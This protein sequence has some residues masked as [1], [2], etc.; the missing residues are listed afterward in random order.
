M[1]AGGLPPISSADVDAFMRDVKLLVERLGGV[2]KAREDARPVSGERHAIADSEPAMSPRTALSALRSFKNDLDTLPTRDDLVSMLAAVKAALGRECEA[3]REDVTEWALAHDA[4]DLPEFDKIWDSLVEVSVTPLKLIAFAKRHGWRGLAKDEFTP[5]DDATD[6]VIREADALSE[7]ARTRGEERDAEVEAVSEQ[8]VY[9]SAAKKW[10]ELGTGIEHD[11][12]GLS[13]STLGLRIAPAGTVGQKSAGAILRNKGLVREVVGKTYAPGLP[14]LFTGEVGSDVGLWFNTATPFPPV[15]EATEDDVKP[16]LDHV[17]WLFPDDYKSVL[18]W[19]AYTIHRPAAKIR[20]GLCVI[21]PQGVGKDLM[22]KPIQ[23]YLGGKHYTNV[24][25]HEMESDFN[26]WIE[27]KL[28]IGQELRSD[29]RTDLYQKL[30][31]WI[32]GTGDDTIMVNVKMKTPY[33][34][35]NLASWFFMSNHDN[36]FRIEADERRLHVIR[37]APTEAR[38]AA[39]YDAY[40]RWIEEPGSAQKVAGYLKTV[41]LAEFSADRCPA[42]TNAKQEMAESSM[43]IAGEWLLAQFREEG[44]MFYGRT[45]VAGKEL[46]KLTLDLS[47]PQEVRRGIH[48]RAIG[49][50][51]KTLGWKKRLTKDD[52][53][54]LTLYCKTRELAETEARFAKHRWAKEVGDT[55]LD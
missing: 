4:C 28:L 51:L 32:S 47:I 48:T 11:N 24:K 14:R 30:K 13:Y 33:P 9:W 44:G 41:D 7:V 53:T 42:W 20:W 8:L 31:E 5:Q 29:G 40:M 43:G 2:E 39:Y 18:W 52:G 34:V 3:H 55:S 22:L 46:S 6:H 37:T 23:M 50:A 27:R 26:A 25:V 12:A 54:M 38:E 10:L 36:A 1:G 49:H 45:V 17:K 16:W 35:R 19:L 21:G 15:V